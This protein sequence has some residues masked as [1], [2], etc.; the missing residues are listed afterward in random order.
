MNFKEKWIADREKEKEGKINILFLFPLMTFLASIALFA[1]KTELCHPYTVDLFVFYVYGIIVIKMCM[2]PFFMLT[3]LMADWLLTEVDMN[4][5]QKTIKSADRFFVALYSKSTALFNNLDAVII[6][7]VDLLFVVVLAVVGWSEGAVIYCIT[8]LLIGF[9]S[10]GLLASK[11]EYLQILE[12]EW[13]QKKLE[14]IG[15]QK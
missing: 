1:T 3:K 5:Q 7:L 6:T 10:K 2:L 12:Y 9:F 15:F 14:K 4:S 11:K 13:F 8:T